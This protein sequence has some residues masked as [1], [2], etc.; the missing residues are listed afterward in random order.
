MASSIVRSSKRSTNSIEADVEIQNFSFTPCEDNK[1]PIFARTT[2]SMYLFN[3]KSSEPSS[4]LGEVMVVMALAFE[5]EVGI[6]IDRFVVKVV[7]I[8]CA[9]PCYLKPSHIP[10][11]AQPSKVLFEKNFGTIALH[12][13]VHL[14]LRWHSKIKK[15]EYF[16]DGKLLADFIIPVEKKGDSFFGTSQLDIGEFV[17]SCAKP[18]S[19]KMVS[20]FDNVEVY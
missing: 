4:G 12:E 13:K 20:S 9:A 1:E 2:I 10:D 18:S 5:P 16:Q 14:G 19:V 17:P 15:V 11:G 8:E 3:S 7:A 6:P